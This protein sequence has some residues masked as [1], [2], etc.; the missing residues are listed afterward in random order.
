M[1]ISGVLAEK[2]TENNYCTLGYHWFGFI[3]IRPFLRR[4]RERRRSSNSAADQSA[5]LRRS[6]SPGV[7]IHN[8]LNT[9][10]FP[11][12]D[13]RRSSLNNLTVPTPEERRNSLPGYFS[14]G[15][16]ECLVRRK[17]STSLATK[18]RYGFD[19]VEKKLS[20]RCVM[21]VICGMTLLFVLVFLLSLYKLMTW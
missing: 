10:G 18:D 15:N 9:L 1:D 16:N 13:F 20:N 7:S 5:S 11:V 2:R 3:M 8:R 14:G 6:S 17:S 12:Q 21:K 4:C 19:P